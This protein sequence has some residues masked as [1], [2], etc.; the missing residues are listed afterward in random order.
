LVGS[1][2]TIT[3]LGQSTAEKHSAVSW[4]IYAIDAIAIAVT[5]KLYEAIFPVNV[6]A[7]D[8]VYPSPT[9]QH[10]SVIFCPVDVCGRSNVSD[11]FTIFT[12]EIL[13]SGVLQI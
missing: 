2:H 12:S 1:L 13:W 4:N 3:G 6:S 8:F 5:S 11:I 10:M 9:M 7:L